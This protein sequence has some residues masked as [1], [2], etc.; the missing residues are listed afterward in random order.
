MKEQQSTTE[1]YAEEVSEAYKVGVSDERWAPIEKM[2]A[3]RDKNIGFNETINDTK[4][5]KAK[6]RRRRFKKVL[7]IINYVML[8][9]A[10]LSTSTVIMTLADSKFVMTDGAYFGWFG[11]LSIVISGL[12]IIMENVIYGGYIANKRN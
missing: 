2:M 12:L 5:F 10:G 11:F 1:R 8:L 7:A 9:I 4:I 6:A 3:E